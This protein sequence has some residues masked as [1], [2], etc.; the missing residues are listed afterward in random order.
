MLLELNL[1]RIIDKKAFRVFFRF[2]RFF[3]FF[4]FQILGSFSLY[5]NWTKVFYLFVLSA[6]ISHAMAQRLKQV[7]SDLS[8]STRI[9]GGTPSFLA[10]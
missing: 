9:R 1:K 6:C 4:P 2:V 7:L 5:A 10:P 3:S 8:C